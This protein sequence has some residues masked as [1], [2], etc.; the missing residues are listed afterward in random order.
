M[1]QGAALIAVVT[2][3]AR[4]AGFGRT[5]VFVQA[6]GADCVGSVYTTVNTLPNIVFDIVAGGM[7]SALVVPVVAPALAAGDMDRA[8]RAVSALL[9]WTLLATLAVAG[10]VAGLAPVL[11]RVLLG[12]TG[13]PGAASLGVR[14]LLVF[15]PQ[16]VFYGVGAVLGGAL[17][18]GHRF[19]WPAVAP[20]LS[21]LTVIAAYLVYGA[22]VRATP[23]SAVIGRGPELVLSVGTTLGV[24]VLALCLV[25]PLLRGGIRP[26]LTLRF[27]DGLAA[28]ARRTALAGTAALAAQQLAAA[29]MLRL[30]NDGTT[31]GLAVVVTTAQTVFLL[32][33]AVLAVPVAT[34]SYPRLSTSWETGDRTTFVATLDRSARLVVAAAAVGTAVLVAVAEPTGV[35]LLSGARTTAAART[36][37]APAMTGFAVGLIGWSLVALLARSLYAAGRVRAAAAGQVVGQL[38]VIVVDVVLA[39]LLP[40]GDRALA[41][42]LGNAV[43]VTVAA[44]WLLVAASRLGDV[45]A[46]AALARAVAAAVAGG[47]AGALVGRTAAG[48]GRVAALGWGTGAGALAAVVAGLIA[49]AADPALRRRVAR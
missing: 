4:L 41:L 16:V 18:A 8:S 43:G 40:V 6:V 10:I 44:V 28:V 12:D 5:V 37:F 13:C 17:Q 36:Q 46:P 35:L 1:A 24:V 15:A 42:G 23:G 9:G 30:A 7:L 26:R 20:L 31:S 49:V 3:V 21:S 48:G 45:V 2:V 11:V 14:M 22:T 32:P 38:V 33:W 39:T 19:G 27:P 34:A 47:V 25:V 29:V